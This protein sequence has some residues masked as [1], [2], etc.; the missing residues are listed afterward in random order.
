MDPGL[1]ARPVGLVTPDTDIEV[2]NYRNAG[3]I[4]VTIE[5]DELPAAAYVRPGAGSA[6]GDIARVEAAQNATLNAMT[7]QGVNYTV[8]GTTELVLSAML[9]RVDGS[10]LGAIKQLPGVKHAYVERIGTF[11]NS[12]SVPFV[13]A[14]TAWAA[15]YTGAGMRVGL[16]DS[17]IDYD[18]VN[19]GG[20]GNGVPDPGEF[21][22]AKIAG[23][24]DF[25]GDSWNPSPARPLFPMQIPT[26]RMGT[27]RMSVAQWRA[28]A[29]RVA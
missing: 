3:L 24:Y 10:A 20:N 6:S 29:C 19:F 5:L 17:G 22:S 12:T 13:N 7:A 16:I 14:L 26:T 23:G 27:A 1:N 8:L 28:L 25:V 2:F 4:N 9:V 11:D 18:H 15:G 21:P